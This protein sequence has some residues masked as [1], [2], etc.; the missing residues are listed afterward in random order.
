MKVGTTTTATA[1]RATTSGDTWT[2]PPGGV[3]PGGVTPG[4]VVSPGGGAG[5]PFRQPLTV[6]TVLPVAPV[7]GALV[8]TAPCGRFTM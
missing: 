3:S 5:G 4:G 1:A 2:V 7:T 6:T 8:T